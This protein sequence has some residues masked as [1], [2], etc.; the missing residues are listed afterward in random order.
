MFPSARHLERWPLLLAVALAAMTAGHALELRLEN[1][2]LFGDGRAAYS[3]VAQGPIVEISIALFVFTLSL[4]AVRLIGG[5]SA[6]NGPSED[7]MLPALR[8]VSAM[9]TG[10]AA[11]RILSIQIPALLAA[12]LIEQRLSGMAHP[13]FNAVLGNGH[14]TTL[15]SQVVIGIFAAWAVVGLSRV[16]CAHARWLARAARSIGAVFLALPRHDVGVSL[17]AQIEIDSSRPRRR[18]LLAFRLANRPPPATAAA[19]A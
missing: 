3:H 6:A 10:G 4:L 11:L 13:T 1:A 19:R 2:A 12:E 18:S 9:G 16:A 8:Q 17:R 14:V 15:F 7:W 5:A